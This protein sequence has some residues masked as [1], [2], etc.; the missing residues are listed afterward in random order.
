MALPGRA[1]YTLFEAA[2]RWGCTP[3]DITEW[4]TQ[5][6]YRLLVSIPF[7]RSGGSTFAGLME[8]NPPDLLPVFRRDGS[9]DQ[10]CHIHRIK[11]ADKPESEWVFVD[12]ENP[13]EV[14]QKDILISF[15]DAEQFEIDCELRP[16]A[17][18]AEG[19][20]LYDWDG[21]FGYVCK[22]I[23]NEG[24]PEN[25]QELVNEVQDWFQRQSDGKKMPDA[26]TIRKRL[27]PLW[28]DL[29]AD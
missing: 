28:R 29:L 21:M 12:P 17:P 3:A 1:F 24:R 23:H 26:S 5:G 22:R 16:K 20:A 19:K 15:K 4:A 9:G 18:A 8:V 27:N 2:A 10:R 6:Y 25:L 14:S 13:V 7:A 11:P